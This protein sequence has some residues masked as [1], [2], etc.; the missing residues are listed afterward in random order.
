MHISCFRRKTLD[1]PE[2]QKTPNPPLVFLY[3]SYMTRLEKHID[4]T[5]KSLIRKQRTEVDC[6]VIPYTFLSFDQGIVR[7]DK[8]KYQSF[9]KASGATINHEL[10]MIGEPIEIDGLEFKKQW[11]KG[12]GGFLLQ[13]GLNDSF[14]GQ[15]KYYPLDQMRWTSHKNLSRRKTTPIL[16]S[17]GRNRLANNQTHHVKAF[18]EEKSVNAWANDSRCVVSDKVLKKRLDNKWKPELAITTPRNQQPQ[19]I[20]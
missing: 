19:D 13:L 9:C 14:D 5:W 10:E 2:F 18:G 20:S 4:D 11:H 1:F 7:Y 3:K 8:E 6:P 16:T 17:Y 15:F 12:N